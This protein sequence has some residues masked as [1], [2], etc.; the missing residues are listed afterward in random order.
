MDI[1]LFG[2]QGSG[3]GTQAKNVAAAFGY[4]IFETGAELRKIAQEESELGR[5]VKSFIDQG[6]LAPI[7]VVM[8]VVDK[9]IAS[10]PAS[11]KMLFDGIPR[12]E[13]QRLHFDV[14]MAGAK[15]EFF[16]MSLLVNEEECV[17]RIL[18]RAAVERRAD[19]RSEEAIRRRMEIFKSQ[20]AP[21]IEVY[22]TRGK[23]FDIDGSGSEDAVFRRIEAVISRVA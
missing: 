19:D 15:R 10:R 18:A 6:L 20:T 4:E 8:A 5:T 2:I 7:E 17:Q 1:V 23:V 16:C 9:A 14:S 12:N 22:R 11:T 21:V 3:K 13:D